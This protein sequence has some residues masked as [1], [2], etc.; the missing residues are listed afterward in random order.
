MRII[1]L[2]GMEVTFIAPRH[3]TRGTTYNNVSYLEKN[4]ANNDAS[5]VEIFSTEM[6]ICG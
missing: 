1:I 2:F 6:S 4:G 3:F 5:V